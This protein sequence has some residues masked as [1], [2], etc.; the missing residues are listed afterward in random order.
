LVHKNSQRHRYAEQ[1][2][3]R[4][5]TKNEIARVIATLPVTDEQVNKGSNFSNT[6]ISIAKRAV[7]PKNLSASE[8]PRVSNEP[9][10]MLTL[11][12]VREL[13]SGGLGFQPAKRLSLRIV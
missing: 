10:A 11:R 12:K 4:E 8:F 13:N 1:E 3:K 2:F 5:E 9:R 6:S 7:E